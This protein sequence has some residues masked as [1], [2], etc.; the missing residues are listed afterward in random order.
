MLRVVSG[1]VFVVASFL[2]WSHLFSPASG[3]I[4]CPA[5]SMMTISKWPFFTPLFLSLL[6]VDKVA[7]TTCFFNNSSRGKLSKFSPFQHECLIASFG[8]SRRLREYAFNLCSFLESSRTVMGRSE[9]S[10]ELQRDDR[11]S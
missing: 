5:S 4:A 10:G 7:T 8:T 6:A 3:S 1:I 11:M 2:L 9:I